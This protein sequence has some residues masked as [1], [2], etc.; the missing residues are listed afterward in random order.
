M[1]RLVYLCDYHCK[2]CDDSFSFRHRNL[3]LLL[4]AID[5]LARTVEKLALTCPKCGPHLTIMSMPQVI[6]SARNHPASGVRFR[7]A[8][9]S[10]PDETAPT[11]AGL[12]GDCLEEAFGTPEKSGDTESLRKAS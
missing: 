11:A 7:P 2:R 1:S 8:V 9:S 6:G 5:P 4:G 3:P 12:A 10:P